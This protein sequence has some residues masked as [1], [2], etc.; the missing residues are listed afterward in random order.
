MGHTY[1]Y[2][3]VR[4]V[5]EA[6]AKYGVK[7]ANL[8]SGHGSYTTLGLTHPD[9]H[10]RRNLID[11]WFFPLLRAAAELDAGAGFFAHAFPHEA[12]QSETLYS[13]FTD[14]LT[15][16]LRE[17]NAYGAQIGCR[18]LGIEQM[19]TPHQYPW[20]LEDTRRL[21][22]AGDRA[23]RCGL[24]FYRGSWTSPCKICA[25]SGL[26][27]RKQRDFGW[28]QTVPMRSG[29][30]KAL[31]RG[32]GSWRIWISIR[33]YFPH[34][35][36]ATAIGRCGRLAATV[37]LFICSRQTVSSL[38]I[39]PSHRSRTQRESSA[40]AQSSRRSKLPM[41]HRKIPTCRAAAQKSI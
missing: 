31:L 15:D 26:L 2:D 24:L 7:V 1:L 13:R 5:R 39:F 8:Y 36:T 23:K 34:R 32:I 41:P 10:V 33:H 38:H 40:R 4:Q 20:R 11:N 14:I 18:S 37:R 6:E 19:Y 35:R 30:R 28:A 3:W 21:F 16:G 9:G 27:H 25:R 22:A 12:L 29:E 17:I